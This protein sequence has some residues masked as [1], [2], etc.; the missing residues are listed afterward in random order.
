[1]LNQ[2]TEVEH[3]MWR[4]QILDVIARFKP[5]VGP[6]DREI[7]YAIHIST[8]SQEQLM[9]NVAQAEGV[10]LIQMGDTRDFHLWWP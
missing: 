1:M 3:A 4:H 8:D 5:L 9:R 7:R 2:S 10:V 6:Y